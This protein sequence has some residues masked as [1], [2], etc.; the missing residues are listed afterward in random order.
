[1]LLRPSLVC[2][3]RLSNLLLL[4]LRLVLN[5]SQLLIFDVPVWEGIGLMH[6][7]FLCLY[8]T[9]LFLA[10]SGKLWDSKRCMVLY[11]SDIVVKTFRRIYE[12]DERECLS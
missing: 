3:L 11:A 8:V 12:C 5:R 10:S 2:R 1:M 9:F 4:V 6:Y 7:L